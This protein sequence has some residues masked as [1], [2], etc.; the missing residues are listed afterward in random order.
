MSDEWTGEI[1]EYGEVDWTQ[2]SLLID[3]RTHHIHGWVAT[4]M[5]DESFIERNDT[6]LLVDLTSYEV[7]VLAAALNRTADHLERLADK[8]GIHPTRHPRSPIIDAER[9][10]KHSPRPES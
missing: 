8:A 10:A 7:R 9:Y 6:H 3:V 5:L 1:V 2:P 4:L